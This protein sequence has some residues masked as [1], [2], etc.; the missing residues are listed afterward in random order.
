[1]SLIDILARGYFPKELPKPFVTEPF[2]RAVT[3][4]IALPADWGK[5]ADRKPKIPTGKLERYSLARGGLLRRPLSICNP[6]HHFL[7]C[8]ELYTNWPAVMAKANGTPLAATAPELKAVGRAIDGKHPQAARSRLSQQN[9]LG[10]RFILKTDISRF[11]HSIYTHSIPWALHTKPVG[12]AD[13]TL[14]L[15]GNRLDFWIRFG[16]DQQTIGIPI[17]PDTSLLIA[18]LIMQRCDEELCARIPGLN[19]HR[20]IDD[21]E[22]TFLTRTAA[23]D[24]FHILEAC[25]SDFEL[26]LNPKKTEVQEL[27]QPFESP[28]V[29]ALR[30][31]IIRPSRVGQESDLQI[32]FNVAFQLHKDF[33]GEAVL[34]FA[35][36]RLRYVAVDNAN[37]NL[38][39][40]LVLNCV[41]PEPACLPY[42]LEQIIL[43]VNAGA[44]ALRSEIE[45][46]ANLLITSHAPLNHTS[47]VANALWACLALRIPL[48]VDAVD[49]V[50]QCENSVVALLALDVEENGLTTKP[51]D[52]TL[53]STHM[54]QEALYDNH[55][56]LAYEANIKGWLPS[57]R[58][59]D[60]VAADANFGYLKANNVSFYDKRLATPPPS[61]PIVLP[62]LPTVSRF[63]SNLSP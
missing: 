24:A 51:L 31:I 63:G 38:F 40:R 20:F 34:Q 59:A 13:H 1:V 48:N 17:G 12:K 32:F 26:A 9:R 56:L 39:Q 15:L 62:T 53:W 11:Y 45:E 43:R 28:W 27:P 2:A 42:A 47:E 60:N 10:K 7:L 8:K 61:H 29:T 14:T 54:T 3:G 23:E 35:L 22:L 36:S 41:L 37:W 5:S 55:W 19:G 49:A 57:V 44:V 58:G 46:I 21:Y 30:R 50:S 4:T 6:L 16:Q 52:K 18:E 25:L 33:P